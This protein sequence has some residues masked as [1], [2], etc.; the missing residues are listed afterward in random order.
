[1][2][3]IPSERTL[4]LQLP[5]LSAYLPVVVPYVENAATTFG[6]GREEVLKLG[7]ATEEIF[8]FLAE[9]ICCGK[10]LEIE[11][12]SGI[13]YA[14]VTFRFSGTALN[15]GGLN[16]T[17][18]ANAAADGD[19]GEMGLLLASRAVDRLQLGVGEDRRI[20]LAIAK[21]KTYPPGEDLLP[22][23]AGGEAFTVRAPNT[24]EIKEFSLRVDQG[25]AAPC[26]PLFFHYPGKVV[27]MIASGEYEAT[28]AVA[29]G[30][31]V[32]GGLLH[33]YRTERII[34]IF[35]PF[36]FSAANRDDIERSVFEACL[37][38]IARRRVVAVVAL[39]GLPASL[40]GD[41]DTLGR[42]CYYD[43]DGRAGEQKTFGRLLN[44][45]PGATIWTA[46]ELSAY[47]ADE[48]RRLALA[49]EIKIFHDLG[50][51]QT[52]ASIFS[53]ETLRD[54][55]NA[56]LRPLWPGVDSLT[57]VARHVRHLR[58]EGF[59]DIHFL[60]DLGIPWHAAL[61]PALL[62]QGFRPE[63]IIPFG[64]RADVVIFQHHA[65]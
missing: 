24:E 59:R 41:F 60:L 63:T 38:R 7:L 65:S 35:G 15:L 36:S 2:I 56:I 14:S 27:D 18:G 25:P 5:A 26:R 57:N 29:A 4:T 34:Q 19:L 11:C 17:S 46:A 20:S 39:H 23:L 12:R 22:P 21:D 64:G 50:E 58:E 51:T 43:E 3:S 62:T 49:R 40:E 52:G 31:H 6:L 30:G 44:E 47:L 28:V 8:A 13:Y 54:R 9:A 45:D 48:Y 55:G 32:V 33:H 16:I 42:L 37:S 1:M 10:P 53:V 61:A